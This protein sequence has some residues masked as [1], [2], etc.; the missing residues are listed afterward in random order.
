MSEE[1]KNK[2]MVEDITPMNV[3]FAQWYTDVV[4][5]A[6]L[7]DYSCVKGCMIVE[8]AGYA[9]WEN[10]Q[11]ELDK[12]F[13]ATGVENCAM[14]IFI[15]ESLLQKEKDHVEGFA[16]EVAWVTHGGM[17][18]LQERLCVRPTSE[19]LFCDYYSRHVQSYRD[20]PKLYNQWCSVVRWEKTTRPFLRSR[21]FWW[22]EGHTAHATAEEARERTEMM[23]NLYADFCEEVLAIPVIRGQKTEK[24][25]YANASAAL[26]SAAA[27]SGSMLLPAGSAQNLII[28]SGYGVSAIDTM[29]PTFLI[30]IPVMAL[31][32]IIIILGRNLLRDRIY[33]HAKASDDTGSRSLRMF[34][35]CLLLV[36]ALSA[37]KLFFWFDV[38]IVFLAVVIVFDRKV[39]LKADYIMLVS[40]MFVITAAE[41]FASSGFL[42][43]VIREG[44]ASHP[45][46][47]PYIL[48]AFLSPSVASVMLDSAAQHPDTLLLLVN[49]GGMAFLSSASAIPLLLRRKS[50]AAMLRIAIGTAISLSALGI[51][52]LL[53][54][55]PV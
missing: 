14:P 1:N 50:P 45:V 31:V 26:V 43:P 37:S 17:E 5:K 51:L 27:Y 20:L 36:V 55:L 49:L 52:F 44:M 39:F 54:D 6:Q 29:Y 7:A 19:T 48:S 33:M 28:S 3:D 40:F 10:I 8:P 12:R 46:L 23:L 34:Y 2:K 25:R 22:Q 16:P 41:S 9:L 35:I 42:E 21:E 47:L 32:L 24:E 4:R 30:S 15:P 53:K 38:L 13:K 18:E 11:H